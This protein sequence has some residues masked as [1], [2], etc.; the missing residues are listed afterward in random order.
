MKLKYFFKKL[1]LKSFL[2]HKMFSNDLNERYQAC[3]IL[4]AVGDAM[5]YSIIR[6]LTNFNTFFAFYFK[7]STKF[8]GK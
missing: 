1:K 2:Q 4:H 3:M 6:T 8:M 5:G 7:I